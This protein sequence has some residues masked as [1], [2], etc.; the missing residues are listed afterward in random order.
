MHASCKSENVEVKS[1]NEKNTLVKG[2]VTASLLT[3]APNSLNESSILFLGSKNYTIG[4]DSVGNFAFNAQNTPMIIVDNNQT[5]SMHMSTFSVKNVDL[6]GDLVVQGITQFRMIWREEFTDSKGW[7]GSVDK[8]G[9]S[10]CSGIQMLGGYQ[11]FGR[12]H[13][14]KTFIELPEHK[15][16]R[17]RATFH[18]I[19][20]WVGETGYMKLGTPDGIMEYVWTDRHFH[21]EDFNTNICGGE[22]GDDKFSVPIDV[23]VLHNSER[24]TIAFG[25]TI[26]GDSDKQSWGISGLEIHIR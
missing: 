1:V 21:K 25:S 17:I 13:V 7:S 18:F 10:N 22:T 3:I 20:Q 6:G 16:L 12:G 14:E 5:I 19:D 26:V 15:E 9:V 11:N 24:F 8:L 2:G 4:V 23:T